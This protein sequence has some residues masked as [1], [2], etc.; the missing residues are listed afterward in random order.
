MITGYRIMMDGRSTLII[1]LSLIIYTVLVTAV[2]ILISPQDFKVGVFRP[3]NTIAPHEFILVLGSILLGVISSLGYKKFALDLTVISVLGVVLLDLDHLPSFLGISQPIR[4][5]HSFV[6][7][8]LFIFTL[9][10][11]RL[12]FDKIL[13][14]SSAFLIHNGV[15]TGIFPVFWPILNYYYSLADFKYYLIFSGVT[16]AYLSGLIKKR[17]LS[18]TLM[19][20]RY[21]H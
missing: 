5:A 19:K 13:I 14:L 8:S 11:M 20:S 4:P 10:M 18:Q 3:V 1:S 9:C 17:I 21:M 6:L 12:P 2:S 15:D 16:L 7:F